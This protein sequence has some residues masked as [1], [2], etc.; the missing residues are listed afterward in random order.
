MLLFPRFFLIMLCLAGTHDEVL[1]SLAQYGIAPGTIPITNGFSV[2]NVEEYRQHLKKLRSAERL[3][4][5]RRHKISVP[6]EFDVLFG[7]GVP[8]QMHPGNVQL[9]G[10]VSE[11]YKSYEKAAKG[12]KIKI[13]QEIVE[14]I[15][16][17]S[18]LF[19]R[20]DGEDSWIC[21]EDG[22]ARKKVSN[23]FRTL[24]VRINNR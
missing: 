6:S 24:R 19:L 1:A 2:T 3:K 23:L 12:E 20:P 13:A 8:C 7:K 14:T 18:G 5:P 17:Q 4:H 21:V 16:E 15:Q 10:I 11:R 9:R 22:I